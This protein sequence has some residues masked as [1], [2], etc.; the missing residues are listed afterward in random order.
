MG[1]VFIYYSSAIEII[2]PCFAFFCKCDKS[3]MIIDCFMITP[4]LL[5]LHI[6]RK[7]DVQKICLKRPRLRDFLKVVL[8]LYKKQIL[9]ASLECIQWKF[10]D[11][12]NKHNF[13]NG[14][15]SRNFVFENCSKMIQTDKM[16]QKTYISPTAYE[17]HWK[18]P[19]LRF[20]ILSKK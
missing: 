18:V 2:E 4:S 20:R 8:N 15:E 6:F 17:S 5:S 12:M 11:F 1:V 14:P 9:I 3:L 19:R 7:R 10:S 13:V 16:T